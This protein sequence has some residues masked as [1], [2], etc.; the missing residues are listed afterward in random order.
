MILFVQLNMNLCTRKFLIFAFYALSAFC[1][2]IGQGVISGVIRDE[3][4]GQGLEFA[5]VFIPEQSYFTETDA[6]GK[7]ALK[8]PALKNCIIKVSRV[9]YNPQEKY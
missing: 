5:T 8:I 1:C 3:H 4:T 7:Y 9:G 2:V 6:T